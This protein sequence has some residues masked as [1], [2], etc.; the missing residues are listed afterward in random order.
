MIDLNSTSHDKKELISKNIEDKINLYN[1]MS[2]QKSELKILV[3]PKE[4]ILIKSSEEKVLFDN[5]N[6]NIICKL[7]N[8]VNKE[9]KFYKDIKEHQLNIVIKT[10]RE[11]NSRNEYSMD[12]PFNKKVK[13]SDDDN[14][15]DL[16][17]RTKIL[18]SKSNNYKNEKNKRPSTRNENNFNLFNMD[19]YQ[20]ILSRRNNQI[21]KKFKNQNNLET[22]ILCN[23]NDYYKYNFNYK[24][25]EKSN[26]SKNYIEEH[27]NDSRGKIMIEYGTFKENNTSNKS[28]NNDPYQKSIF[29]NIYHKDSIKKKIDMEIYNIQRYKFNRFKSGINSYENIIPINNKEY[30]EFIQL[31]G[32]N[33]LENNPF[34]QYKQLN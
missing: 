28:E 7:D 13:L 11:K 14:C 12:P 23:Q 6:D 9:N 32:L 31:V 3:N 16:I 1:D 17:L 8:N 24:K 27:L 26:F 33:Q 2:N 4:N 30:D 18:L 15:S 22:K 34:Y 21:I 19:R 10:I 25:N 29:E 5:M 20:S